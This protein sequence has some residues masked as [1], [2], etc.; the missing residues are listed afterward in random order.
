MIQPGSKFKLGSSTLVD[1]LDE[2]RHS[3]RRVLL[4]EL[5]THQISD[6]PLTIVARCSG[7]SKGWSSPS[8]ER[9][10]AV[11]DRSR[12]EAVARSPQRRSASVKNACRARPVQRRNTRICGNGSPAVDRRPTRRRER[13][14]TGGSG[15]SLPHYLPAD[16]AS[17]CVA[18][19][20]GIL[21]EVPARDPSG[22]FCIW[23]SAINPPEPSD[24]TRCA[25]SRNSLL[26]PR[27]LLCASAPR[28]GR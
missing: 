15:S 20:G 22:D 19:E 27:I 5:E 26:G 23:Y 17:W 21:R 11:G 18:Q 9:K 8:G 7:A 25:G 28:L 1:D 4:A 13:S 2:F 24:I 12:R 10:R 14:R 6:H 3:A 16:R